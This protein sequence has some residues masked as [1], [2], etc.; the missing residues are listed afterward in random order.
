[1]QLAMEETTYQWLNARFLDFF[2]GGG[3]P[4]GAKHINKQDI[5]QRA[6]LLN[7]GTE[8]L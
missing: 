2:M 6:T 8:K 4:L 5:S 3:G 1:M 7:T